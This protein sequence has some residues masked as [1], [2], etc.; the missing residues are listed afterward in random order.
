VS[1]GSVARGA[2]APEPED[3]DPLLDELDQASAVAKKALGDLMPNQEEAKPE[4][5]QS[6]AAA[7]PNAEPDPSAR[8]SE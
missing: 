2:L 5:P 4:E 6:E 7:D 8:T 3:T 1:L